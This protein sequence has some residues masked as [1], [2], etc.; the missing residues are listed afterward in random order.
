MEID[1]NTHTAMS[2]HR[3]Q[4]R[5]LA[6]G[7]NDNAATMYDCCGMAV[8]AERERERGVNLVFYCLVVAGGQTRTVT[9]EYACTR[10]GVRRRIKAASVGSFATA[11]VPSSPTK[12]R[13]GSHGREESWVRA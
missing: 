11:G 8:S 12:M 3:Q 7:G 10:R 6:I 2:D 5:M 4:V 9:Q 1:A 13:R